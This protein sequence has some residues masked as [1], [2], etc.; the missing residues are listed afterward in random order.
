M[1][2]SKPQSISAVIRPPI[3]RTVN[4]QFLSP[5][6]KMSDAV[7]MRD[8]IAQLQPAIL[9]AMQRGY[10]RADIAEILEQAGI[11]ITATS[12]QYYLKAIAKAPKVRKARV[13]KRTLSTSSEAAHILKSALFAPS[14][15]RASKQRHVDQVI[16]FLL[17][18]LDIE[19]VD[20]DSASSLEAQQSLPT[21]PT[22]KSGAQ[23]KTK[24]H[25]K[26]VKSSTKQSQTSSRAKKKP[27][28]VVLK[29]GYTCTLR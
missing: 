12:L 10:T 5:P 19:E 1:A 2:K 26:E 15:T 3:I 28:A 11:S 7:S 24:S 27:K 6:E 18:D 9:A 8:A 29:L 16:S 14:H 20:R 25:K 17:D 4:Q 22:P 13:S 21:Q 23:S